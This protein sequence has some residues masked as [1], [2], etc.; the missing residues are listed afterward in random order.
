[1]ALAACCSG[2]YCSVMQ[3]NTVLCQLTTAEDLKPSYNVSLWNKI[4]Q[5]ALLRRLKKNKHILKIWKYLYIVF[6][7]LNTFIFN[8]CFRFYQLFTG[9]LHP[10]NERR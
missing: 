5:K 6:G 9:S 10:S 2:G 1:M 3:E 4:L 7:F 8:N